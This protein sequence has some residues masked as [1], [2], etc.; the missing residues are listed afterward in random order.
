[1]DTIRT[2]AQSL[3][4]LP[5]TEALLRVVEEAD[6]RLGQLQS[7]LD[8]WVKLGERVHEMRK[9]DGPNVAEFDLP[10]LTVYYLRLWEMAERRVAELTSWHDWPD[11]EKGEYPP[12]ETDVLTEIVSATGTEYAVQRISRTRGTYGNSFTR[13]WRFIQP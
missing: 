12:D 11:E 6:S 1:M 8:A 3:A 10:A 13:R 5:P 9:Y 2:Y 4:D 7:T